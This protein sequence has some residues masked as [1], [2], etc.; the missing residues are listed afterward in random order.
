MNDATAEQQIIGTLICHPVAI[1]HVE[2]LRGSHFQVDI[3]ADLFD[4][5]F[6]Q[7]ASTGAVNIASLTQNPSV[8]AA[9]VSASSSLVNIGTLADKVIEL[10]N[11]KSLIESC[12]SIAAD[13][14]GGGDVGKALS[15]LK[16]ASELVSLSGSSKFHNAHVVAE[17]IAVQM[18]VDL[19]CTPTGLSRLDSALGG[20]FYE[21]KAYGF[22]ARKK[23]GKTILASTVSYNLNEAGLPHLFICGEM[24]ENEVHQRCLARKMNVYPSAFRSKDRHL[25]AGKVIETA[26]SMQKN[27]IYY[28]RPG[29]TFEELKNAVGLAKVR[30]DIK[31]FILDYWQLVGGKPKGLTQ[32]E[33]SGDVAQWIADICRKLGIWAMVMAQI[34]QDG[35]TRGGEGI[36]LSF[37][38]V[39]QIHRKDLSQPQAW[40]EMM[41]TRYTGWC[42]VGSETVPGLMMNEKGPFFEEFAV[43]EKE[44][45][46]KPLFSIMGK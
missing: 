18:K 30:Y 11:R 29:I 45:K 10:A 9:C 21:G 37:D 1:K 24:G 34:N 19:P 12:Q 5:I 27:A 3:Y 2:S 31:G 33:H 28:D 26:R 32:A 25:L 22:A 16:S 17:N 41:D 4:D 20:G 38:Q 8:V 14:V 13:L 42:N 15:D 40:F 7:I 46:Q 35:N 44:D 36:R 39:Y 23:V 43:Y 6:K